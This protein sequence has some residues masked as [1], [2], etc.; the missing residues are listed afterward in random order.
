MKA[1]KVTASVVGARGY[2]GLEL[3]KLLIQHPAV[4]LLY[5]F[6]TKPF[7]LTDDLMDSRAAGI[8]C[9]TDAELMNHLTD[10]VFLATP[11]E[12]SAEL[13]PRLVEAGK[14]VIDLS[15]AF[16]FS[17][18]MADYGLAPF[19]GPWKS[20]T[21]LVANPGCYAS[22]VNLALMPLLKQGL[23]RPDSVVID[24]KSGTTG[25]GRK[26]SESQL[27]AEVDGECLPYRVGQHQ[28]LPEIRMAARKHANTDFS[29]HFVTH[30]LPTKRGISAA[31]FAKLKSDQGL[32]SVESAYQSAYSNYPLVRF[33][34]DIGKLAKL[35]HVVNTPFT[36]ISYTVI[37][38]KL[39]VFS[40]IDNLLKGAASQAV[41]NLNR[42]L[43]LPLHFSLTEEN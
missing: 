3:T 39:Y 8:K 43:D 34:H 14:T 9:M 6:A 10:V 7:Q 41:E 28:H 4:N 19:C 18:E 1:P 2:S 37:E 13:A 40:C 12:A 33:G 32:E 25:A 29:P 15:N 30:L 38:D 22:A 27:F 17:P 24:A 23:I 11:A 35:S 5:G 26:A 16:R 21:R 20:G 31:I 36:H 42:Y